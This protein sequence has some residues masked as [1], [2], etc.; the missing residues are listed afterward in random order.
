MITPNKPNAATQSDLY[1][2]CN[3]LLV[4]SDKMEY[5]EGQSR[6]NNLVIDGIVESPGETWAE[7]EEKVKKVLTE[8]LQLQSDTEM[9]RAHCTGKP[10][11]ERPRLIVVKFLRYKDRTSILQR[12]RLFNTV[13]ITHM[14]LKM[15]LIL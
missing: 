11:G 8:K 14:T 10:G 7:A 5:L 12:S 9:E 4:V 15:T 13:T 1:K 6:H 3:S 2:M